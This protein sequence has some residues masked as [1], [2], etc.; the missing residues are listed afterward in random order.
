MGGGG[1][2]IRGEAVRLG[3]RAAIGS[4]GSMYLI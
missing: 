2:E 4:V 1:C 3:G